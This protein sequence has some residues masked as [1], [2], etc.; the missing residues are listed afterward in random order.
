MSN[1]GSSK[2]CVTINACILAGVW[3]WSVCRVVHV[4]HDSKY[5]VCCW[6]IFS[7]AVIS[8]IVKVVYLRSM[9]SSSEYCGCP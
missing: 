1:T 4:F 6:I 5:Y 8:T 3:G 7:V 9:S 2:Y